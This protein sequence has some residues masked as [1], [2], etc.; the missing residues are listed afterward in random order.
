MNF[1][2]CGAEFTKVN[3]KKRIL[4]LVKLKKYKLKLKSSF[5]IATSMFV[6]VYFSFSQF[7]TESDRIK[8]STI[9]APHIV[10]RAKLHIDFSSAY[11]S[12]SAF[13]SI[14]SFLLGYKLNPYGYS[15]VTALELLL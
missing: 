5:Q 1:A 3:V 8:W 4:K 7:N 15:F 14:R 12:Q 9:H 2:F 13:F 10:H 11:H 6:A